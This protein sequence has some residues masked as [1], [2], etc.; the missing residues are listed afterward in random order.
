MTR[1]WELYQ[2][3][4][5]MLNDYR[6]CKRNLRE[7]SLRINLVN[8]K[9]YGRPLDVVSVHQFGKGDLELFLEMCLITIEKNQ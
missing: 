5:Q 9:L 7:C 4:I 8:L 1:A 2:F 3:I 6:D